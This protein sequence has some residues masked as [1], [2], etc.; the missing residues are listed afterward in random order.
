M[1]AAARPPAPAARLR[2]PPPARSERRC[3]NASTA[4]LYSGWLNVRVPS[5]GATARTHLLDVLRADTFVAGTYWP[6][7]CGGGG[8]CLLRKLQALGPV[9]AVR[10]D[11][12]LTHA[13]LADRVGRAPHFKAIAAEF[14]YERTFKGLS[15]WAP[16]LGNGNLS[17]LRELNDY[18][19]SLD[20]LSE[21][22]GARGARYERV[23]FSRLEVR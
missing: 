6:S 16:L 12:Q 20:L 4:V 9:C 2:R 11:P 19:R 18:S 3:L 8:R 15:V 13:Q 23:V 1:A 14:D 21:H 22:E 7:D 17:V 5:H 10:L